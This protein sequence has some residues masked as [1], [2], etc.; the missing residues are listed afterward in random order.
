MTRPF[1]ALGVSARRAAP[2]VAALTLLAAS[3]PA[4]AN[5]SVIRQIMEAKLG[6]RVDGVQPTP[7]PG[8]F[9][10]RFRTERGPQIVYTDATASHIFVGRLY[11]AKTD[12]NL[13]EERMQKLLAIRFDT[14]PLDLAVKV[15]RGNG[16]RVLAIFTDPYCPACRSFEAELAKLDNVTIHYFLYP[17]IRPE[18]AD[19]SKAVWCAKDRA[20][21]WLELAQRG[22]Q[23]AAA[24]NCANPVDKVL[25]LGRSLGVSATPT[26]FLGNGERLSGGVSA[27]KLAALLDAA[28]PAP[29]KK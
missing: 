22:Q 18:L 23:P 28:T 16:R 12:R 5:E 9:E 13:T 24:A 2:L 7:V 14:L 19:H 3:V 8:I 10:V 20:K 17:V 26:I 15:T 1:A 27:E 4:P 21:T 25:D 6:A 29:P 11:E